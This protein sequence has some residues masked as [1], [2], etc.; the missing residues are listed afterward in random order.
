MR[1]CGCF[2]TSSFVLLQN[3]R[4][5]RTIAHVVYCTRPMGTSTTATRPI[6]SGTPGTALTRQQITTEQKTAKSFWLLGLEL[7]CS[8]SWH[9]VVFLFLPQLRPIMLD[10]TLITTRLI[11]GHP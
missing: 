11:S 2:C 4:V 10:I 8:A 7:T 1:D 6:A 9:G 3:S 5:S